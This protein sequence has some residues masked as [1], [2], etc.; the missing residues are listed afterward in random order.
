[1]CLSSFVEN[2]G[3]GAILGSLTLHLLS[4]RIV[5]F[6]HETLGDLYQQNF[7]SCELSMGSFHVMLR[8][9]SCYKLGPHYPASVDIHNLDKNISFIGVSHALEH[10]EYRK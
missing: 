7:F 1:M 6:A 8:V 5:K 2:M 10:K 3:L 9:T 4:F